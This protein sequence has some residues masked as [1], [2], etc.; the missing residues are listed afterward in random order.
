MDSA[1]TSTRY[2]GGDP[3][4]EMPMDNHDLYLHGR[5]DP[6]LDESVALI[7]SV[8]LRTPERHVS[9]M[10]DDLFSSSKNGEPS[11]ASI[12]SYPSVG[13]CSSI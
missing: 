13:M 7:E 11:S 5:I 1:G 12:Q 6:G 4:V 9:K 8:E 3:A 2:E 10:D